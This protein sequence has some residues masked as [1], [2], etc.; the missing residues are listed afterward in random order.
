M[1]DY[2]KQLKVRVPP[3][4]HKQL[5]DACQMSG[6]NMQKFVREAVQSALAKKGQQHAQ[7]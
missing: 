5:K 2:G 6:V 3:A 4:L 7:V 1:K